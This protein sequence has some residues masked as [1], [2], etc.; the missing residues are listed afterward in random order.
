MQLL[1][2]TLFYYLKMSSKKYQKRKF[3]FYLF[4]KLFEKSCIFLQKGAISSLN[5]MTSPSS[6]ANAK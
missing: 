5:F 6:E 4:W 1:G 2:S 3:G